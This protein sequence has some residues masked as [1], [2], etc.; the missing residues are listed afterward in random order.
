MKNYIN[1][2]FVLYAF[3]IPLSRAGISILTASLVILWF[4]TDDFKAKVSFLKTNKVLK[5]LLAFLLFSILSLLWSNDI[6][7]GINYLRKYWYF[8]PIL[9]IAS[10]ATKKYLEYAIS[11]FLAGMFIS[12]ILS[13]G[14]FFELWT[15]KHGSPTFP[16]PFMSHIHYSVY[17]AFTSLLLLNRLFYQT[18]FKWR[19]LYFLYFLSVTAN[20]FLNAGRTGQVAFG[21]SLFLVLFLNV[22]NRFLAFI[23]SSIFISAILFASYQISPVFQARVDIGVQDIQKVIDEENY[24]SSLG[25]RLGVWINGGE[26][27]LDNPILGVGISNN[28]SELIQNIDT[29]HPNMQC[30]KQMPS[31]H[32]FFVQTIVK[33]GL[34]GIFLYIMIYISLFKL[35]LQDKQY[36]N[37]MVIFLGV[38]TV[39]SLVE[40][41]FH[42]QFTQ[43]IFTLFVGIFIA[44]NR[45]ENET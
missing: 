8:L 6:S 3:L 45:I 27:F 35:K 42:E 43:A 5:Y 17:L 19:V 29:R 32:N 34:I 22:K 38:Y 21:V 1:Y 12:E 33:L 30:V 39:S 15:L 41:I 18:N 10:T 16:S 26:I 40:T 36:Y 44:Q 24:C 13:Y 20:L 2:I 25:L 23:S 14:I 37:L 28:M 31:Y 4:F 9:V 7:N 11:A